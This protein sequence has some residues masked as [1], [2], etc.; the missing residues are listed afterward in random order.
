MDCGLLGRGARQAVAKR[1][2]LAA[3][4]LTSGISDGHKVGCSCTCGKDA[5]DRL[6]KK[7]WL[8]ASRGTA[9]LPVMLTHP[10]TGSR[11]SLKVL[12]PQMVS[13]LTE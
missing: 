4:M 8:G 2:H 10:G 13:E 3:A 9:V 12:Q 7:N 6:W 5:V 11:G 1:P